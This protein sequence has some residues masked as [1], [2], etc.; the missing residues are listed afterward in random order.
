M[1]IRVTM[2]AAVIGERKRTTG[3]KRVGSERVVATMHRGERRYGRREE[4]PPY[5]QLS[6][7]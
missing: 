3:S 5:L 6:N 1:E 7:S 2:A 4:E